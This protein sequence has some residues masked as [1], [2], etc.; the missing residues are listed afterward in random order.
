MDTFLSNPTAHCH[1]PN[2]HLIAAIQL[3]NNIKT[4]AAKTEEQSSSILHS[5]LRTYPISAVGALPKTE[6]I[7]LTIRRQRVNDK[8]DADR[9]I[10]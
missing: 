5:P 3:K 7:M 8:N 2:S 10:P 1:A 9:R 6:T 4:R